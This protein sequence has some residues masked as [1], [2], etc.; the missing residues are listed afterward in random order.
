[1]FINEIFGPTIQGEGKSIGKEVL[2]VRLAFCN[3]K[4]GYCDTPYTWKNTKGEI[5]KMSIQ[6]VFENLLNKSRKTKTV[7]ISGGEPLLQQKELIDLL[8]LLKQHNYWIEIETNGTIEPTD[9]FLSLVDQVNCSPK[10]SCSGNNYQKREIPKVLKKLSQSLKTNFKFVI[11]DIMDMT[12]ILDL[13]DRYDMKEV[14]LMPEGRTKE[15]IEKRSNV[16]R[17]L[18]SIHNFHFTTRLHILKYGSKRGV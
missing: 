12:E 6:E 16:V 18:C 15:E 11:S 3:L 9:E 5:H 10:T 1:M 7:V 2:F 8:K 13:V 14:Y 4:C 17:E